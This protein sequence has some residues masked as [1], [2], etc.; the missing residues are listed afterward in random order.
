MLQEILR[1]ETKGRV[2]VRLYGCF[3]VYELVVHYH[4]L[5]IKPDCPCR[6]EYFLRGEKKETFEL[7]DRILEAL[8]KGT[9]FRDDFRL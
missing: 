1:E 6:L 3:E 4:P 8:E 9:F 2:T 7:F 5:S